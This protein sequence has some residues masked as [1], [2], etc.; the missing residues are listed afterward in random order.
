MPLKNGYGV[1]IGKVKEHHID[2]PDN[3]GRWP[4][5]HI[6]VETY[7]GETFDSA[8]NLK[9]RTE[10]RVQYRDFRNL[11]KIF[12]ANAL[13]KPDGLHLLDSNSSSGALDHLRHEGLKDP[14][15]KS[16]KVD[17]EKR[18][19]IT[20]HRCECTKW[21]LE[22]GINTVKLMQFYLDNVDRVYIFGEP[23]VNGRGIHNVHMTQGDPVNSE[24]SIENGIWQDGA[25]MFEYK[26]PEPHLSILFTKFETQSFN[27]DSNGHPI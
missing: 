26:T 14:I 10:I 17:G 21:W 4:H 20:S 3:E 9:S 8:I 16:D 27:T 23:Y 19:N 18:D 6:T 5:Y 7:S 13:S 2:D 24:F 1:L 12:F 15:C 25:V 11:D 22:T